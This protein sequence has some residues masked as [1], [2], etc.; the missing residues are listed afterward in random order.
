[1][2][3][4]SPLGS[5]K[6]L[7]L[8]V[9]LRHFISFGSRIPTLDLTPRAFHLHVLVQRSSPFFFEINDKIVTE[10]TMTRERVMRVQEQMMTGPSTD[11]SMK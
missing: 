6:V 11:I 4:C 3:D 10:H 7:I 2:D 5:R 9:L 8:L 1:M